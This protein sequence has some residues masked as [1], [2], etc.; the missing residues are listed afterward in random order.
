MA[1]KDTK[2][3]P[4]NPGKPHGAV[5]HKTKLWEQLGD[6]LVNEGAERVKEYL[7]T[8][9]IE[10]MLKHYSN[11]LE[12]FRPKLQRSENTNTTTLTVRFDKED[13]GL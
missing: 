2:F 1:R 11:L 4:G 5:S 3:K 6:M 13:E 10:T 12:Y 7:L 8:C 9:D